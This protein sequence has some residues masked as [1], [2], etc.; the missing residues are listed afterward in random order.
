MSIERCRG[1]GDRRVR[2]RTGDLS[3]GGHVASPNATPYAQLWDA[4]CIEPATKEYKQSNEGA[5]RCT[6]AASGGATP[7]HAKGHA[8]APLSE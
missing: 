3:I 8:K 1:G 5:A 2:R 6:G 7:F 4:D